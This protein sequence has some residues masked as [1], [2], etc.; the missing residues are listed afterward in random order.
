MDKQAQK[1]FSRDLKQNELSE[2][3]LALVAHPLLRQA[4]ADIQAE[5]QEGRV[6]SSF[7]EGGG[8]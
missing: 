3:Q 6:G 8:P 1:N 5:E 4:F 7:G 2:K